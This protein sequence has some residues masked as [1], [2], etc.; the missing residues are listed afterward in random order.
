MKNAAVVRELFDGAMAQPVEVRETWLLESGFGADVIDE[1]QELLR[2]AETSLGPLDTPLLKRDVLGSVRELL[3]DKTLP[4]RIGAYAVTREI[5]RGTMGTVYEAVQ[6]NPRRTVAVKLLRSGLGSESSL[7]RFQREVDALGRLDHRDI[8]SIYEAGSADFG[9]GPRPFL[10]ME[11][12]QGTALSKVVAGPA[13][14]TERLDLLAHLCEAMAHAHSRGVVHRDLK[15]D[16]VMVDAELR[17][18]I[19][20]FGVARLLDSGE[21]FSA[22]A[23]AQG[24]LVGTLQYMSPEQGAGGGPGVDTRSD[25]YA[26]GMMGYELLTGRLPYDLEGLDLPD[27]LRVITEESGPLAGS[28]IGSLKG[29]VETILAKALSKN[30]DERYQSA[31]ELLADIRR[32]LADEPIAA[33][34]ASTAD[35]L[36]RLARKNR[37]LVAGMTVGLVLLLAGLSAMAWGLSEARKQSESRLILLESERAARTAERTAREQLEAEQA[38]SQVARAETELALVDSESLVEFTT[39]ILLAA[40]PEHQGWDVPMSAVLDA[41]AERASRWGATPAVQARVDET[42]GRAYAGLGRFGQ[43]RPLLQRALDGWRDLEGPDSSRAMSVQETLL[44]TLFELADGPAAW[45]LSRDLLERAERLFGLE[46]PR[47]L[48]ADLADAKV[49]RLLGRYDESVTRFEAIMERALVASGEESALVD[50]ARF[51]LGLTHVSANRFDLARD[52]F[53]AVLE[54]RNQE[55]GEEH[56]ETLK[57]QRALSNLDY[58]AGDTEQALRSNQ[59][60]QESLGRLLGPDHPETLESLADAARI[61][62]LAANY[63]QALAVY[64]SAIKGLTQ[65]V[66]ATHSLTLLTRKRYATLLSK[67]DLLSE[68]EEVLDGLIAVGGEQALPTDWLLSAHRERGFLLMRR[69][70]LQAARAEMEA[71]LSAMRM[72]FG[73]RHIELAHMLMDLS[74]LEMNQRKFAAAEEQ[75]VEA[76]AIYREVHG[77]EHAN[78]YY[79][80]MNRGSAYLAQGRHT[81]AETLL[82]GLI[83]RMVP[84]L[85]NEHPSVLR[86]LLWLAEALIRTDRPD[87]ALPMLQ[88]VVTSM[89]GRVGPLHELV[90][91]A[92]YG[93]IEG[94]EALGRFTE[95]NSGLDRISSDLGAIDASES[96]TLELLLTRARVLRSAGRLPEALALLSTLHEQ[97]DALSDR[98]EGWRLFFDKAKVLAL[99]GDLTAAL[100]HLQRA[101][102]IVQNL[103][104]DQS[105]ELTRTLSALAEVCAA[106]GIDDK[107]ARWRVAL[108]AD[109]PQPRRF[110]ED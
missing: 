25:V 37:P 50:R 62:E 108:P 35:Q 51:G 87:R 44:Q 90:L 20:D 72:H 102:A 60:L 77:D 17:P 33:R 86:C 83:Q 32:H 88:L 107:A 38:V 1:V 26:L 69:G 45:T 98:E 74:N 96:Q 57:V 93:E 106:L 15:P 27:A 73:E 100:E 21:G 39:G 109:G 10:V 46:D 67:L 7:Q 99:G 110:L 94:L 76:E 19:L 3:D 65:A 75:L 12:V 58:L 49:L 43:A 14:T 81:D 101:H 24:V 66:G 8:A 16:N 52:L 42:L 11:F 4:E 80:M 2:H 5:G 89:Q 23:T 47:A 29:D 82:V 70:D 55:L 31:A 95:A 53:V 84:L 40:R 59:A 61:H 9:R 85:G 68:A 79:A 22:R 28:V 97:A 71:T 63:D 103:W 30:P 56:L 36:R 54:R 91:R 18:R 48:E 13:S 92:R 64:E 104:G 105:W 41:A 78:V 6:E 34:P